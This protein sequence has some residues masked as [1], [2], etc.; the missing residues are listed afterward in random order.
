[1]YKI[2]FNLNFFHRPH[3]CPDP[4]TKNSTPLNLTMRLSRRPLGMDG[5]RLDRRHIYSRFCPVKTFRPTD[6]EGTFTCCTFSVSRTEN[7][8]ID[9]FNLNVSFIY[10]TL[11]NYR[12]VS[13]LTVTQIFLINIILN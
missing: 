8:C 12:S 11:R 2:N 6:V 10:T 13:F 4:C 5:R 7:I 1:M 9:N 3:K